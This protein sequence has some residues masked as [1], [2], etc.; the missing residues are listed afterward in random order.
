MLSTFV[1]FE[2]VQE[3]HNSSSGNGTGTEEKSSSSAYCC[4][5]CGFTK[6][7]VT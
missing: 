7:L 4:S 5:P 2:E 3:V 1:K 6:S